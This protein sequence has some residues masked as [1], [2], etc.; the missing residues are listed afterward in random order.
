MR[1]VAMSHATTLL[2]LIALWRESRRDSRIQH[3]YSEVR[4]APDTT[5]KCFV[6]VCTCDEIKQG[7]FQDKKFLTETDCQIRTG[8]HITITNKGAKQTH[9]KTLYD[10]KTVLFA[11]C[12]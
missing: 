2:S 9:D 12:L 4:R 10:A 3:D 8:V 7:H 11:R 6:G 1:D 5:A